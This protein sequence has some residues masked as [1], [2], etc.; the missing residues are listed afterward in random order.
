MM[1]AA[2]ATP[3]THVRRVVLIGLVA[4]SGL[5]TGIAVG[6]ATPNSSTF[7]PIALPGGVKVGV[8]AIV[9]ASDGTW[10]AAGS[11]RDDSGEHRPGLWQS[12]NTTD[13]NRVDTVAITPYG[14]VSE[15][16]S[17][18]ASARG[19]V[20][21]GAATGGA[22]GNPRTASWVLRDDG[23]LHEVPAGFELYNG[24][25]QIAVRTI[26]DGPTGW[27][28]F[29]ARNNQNNA[30]GATS[31]TSFT[32]DDFSIHDNDVQLSSGPQESILGLDVAFD[33]VAPGG[34]LIAVGE[35][36]HAASLPS[37]EADT[38]A[39]VWTSPNGV[40]WQRWAPSGL[41]LGGP[42]NQRAQRLSLDGTRV[43]M[44]GL[45]D[46]GVRSRIV[47]WTTDTRTRWTRTV[48][49]ALGSSKDAST[50]VTATRARG[51]RMIVAARVN[52][53]LRAVTS[54]NGRRWS[55]LMLPAG[56]PG[57]NRAVLTVDFDTATTIIGA[58]G[59]DGGGLWKSTSQ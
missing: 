15:L 16:F 57:G 10:W 23:K 29:G 44:A 25:R 50:A 43:L 54:D 1:L 34:Q 8:A 51:R 3:S 40:T 21:L 12:N 39:I 24:V 9:K 13:W 17:V 41:R 27:V 28:I 37:T 52:Q 47:A 32:G 35:R 26:S 55:S 5:W 45:D 30:L 33:S 7:R 46:R 56:I 18:A 53:Q 22:H 4:I 2:H 36:F 58:T 31:W 38:D 42:D 48:I 11:F 6:G 14:E 20:A 59:P 49:T 19:V